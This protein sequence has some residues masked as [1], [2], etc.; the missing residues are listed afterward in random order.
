MIK[1]FH[2][3][4]LAELFLEDK[5][6]NANKQFYLKIQIRLDALEKALCPKDMNF[7]NFNFQT[8]PETPDH[9]SV[10][11]FGKW[12]MTFEWKDHH[13][14]GV[15]AEKEEKVDEQNQEDSKMN[16]E[17][18]LVTEATKRTPTHPG[19]LFKEEILPKFKLSVTDAAQK[20]RISRQMLHKILNASHPITPTMALRFGRFCNNDPA[21]WLRMQQAYD[22]KIAEKEMEEELKKISV[23]KEEHKSC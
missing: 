4:F 19:V 18:Y 11:I 8:F 2:N 14:W 1:S 21:M 5:N 12:A 23:H 22:L 6:Y 16:P 7:P 9:Y 15:N 10:H 3:N 13:A 20:L 17:E